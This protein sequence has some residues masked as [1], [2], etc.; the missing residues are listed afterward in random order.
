MFKIIQAKC[1]QGQSHQGV[2]HGT[3]I[4]RNILLSKKSRFN[5]IKRRSHVIDRVSFDS[6]DGYKKLFKVHQKLLNQNNIP[7]TLGGDHSIGQITIGSTLT[8]FKNDVTVLWIDAHADINT[9]EASTTKNRH[10]TPLAALIGLETA[11]IREI[12]TVLCPTKLIYIGVRDIDQFE[13]QVI[14]SN[15]IKNILPEELKYHIQ[16]IDRVH[17]SFDVDSLDPLLFDS[18]GVKAHK[19]LQ[20]ED[21]RDI[22][23][24]MRD[25]IVAIDICE[26]NPEMGDFKN[27][28]DVLEKIFHVT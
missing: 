25:K 4:L 8:K 22:F 5:P 21:L 7:I 24:L 16:N 19:G 12:K 10:G 6:F 26:F 9:M 13:K 2:A 14:S 23:N 28:V 18:T 11:W 15:N 3:D 1:C 17:I 27:S 20:I